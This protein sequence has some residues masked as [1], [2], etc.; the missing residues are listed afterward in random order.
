MALDERRNSAYQRAL[1]KVVGPETVVLDLG[2]GLGVHGLLAAQLGAKRVCLVEPENVGLLG[3]EAARSNGLADG[4][5]LL[6]GKIEDVDVPE[7]VD[8]ITA[9]FTGNFLLEEDLLP[10]LFLARDRFLN[11]GGKLIPDQAVME[12][13]PVS[14]PELHEREIASWP[15]SSLDLDF[16]SARRYASNAIYY[17]RDRLERARYLSKPMD[18][19]SLDLTTASNTECRAEATY[20]I[21]ESGVC[22]GWAGWFRMRLGSEWLSTAPHEPP[23]HWSPAF[24][25]V[26]PPIA[27][28]KGDQLRFRLVRPPFGPWS[29]FVESGQSEQR[30]STLFAGPLPAAALA[31]MSPHYRPGINDEGEAARFVLSQ[32]NGDRS[33]RDLTD[34]LSEQ[35]PALFADPGEYL[36]FVR[37]VVKQY[38]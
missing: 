31:K 2:A 9:A 32:V 20:T 13:V 6:Q 37:K 18:L 14:A 27:V 4:V 22:H 8:V 5:E 15:K 19:L 29:W 10:S 34:A 11:P 7:R 21:D 16:S 23:V 30:H 26:D 25:P 38:D 36:S 1:A 35:F 17:E 33:I 28:K 24:L 3:L 12:A